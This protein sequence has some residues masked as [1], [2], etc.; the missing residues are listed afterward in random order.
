MFNSSNHRQS[1]Q[2]AWHS[3]DGLI[4]NQ[5]GM[6]VA[7]MMGDDANHR[8]ACERILVM[9][10]ALNGVPTDAI[11]NIPREKGQ[12]MIAALV[13]RHEMHTGQLS[14]LTESIDY[15]KRQIVQLRQ[16]HY[17]QQAQL[18]SRAALDNG[19]SAKVYKSLWGKLGVSPSRVSTGGEPFN[20]EG[21]KF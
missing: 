11:A 17:I 13:L 4:Y 9:A 2:G 3:K 14:R 1:D 8:L 12:N 10:N 6:P 18:A 5:D 7:R 16:T 21:S 15:H 20:L 19:P